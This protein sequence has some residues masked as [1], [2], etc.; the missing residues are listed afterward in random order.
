M[1]ESVLQDGQR[2]DT[3][4]VDLAPSLPRLIL[5]LSGRRYFQIDTCEGLLWSWWS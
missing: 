5:K 2:R 3:D 4:Y 1:G